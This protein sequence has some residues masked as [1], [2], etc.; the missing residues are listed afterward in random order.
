MCTSTLGKAACVDVFHF[1]HTQLEFSLP[2]IASKAAV[3]RILGK[4]A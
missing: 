2:V 4:A 1:P 3:V